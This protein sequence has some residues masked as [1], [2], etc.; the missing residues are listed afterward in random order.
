MSNT[1][2]P[3]L[4]V[5]IRRSPYDSSLARSAVD[6]ALASAALDQTLDVLFLGEGVLQ[7]LPGQNS[8]EVGLT[9]IG[10]LLS[11]F[12]LYGIEQVYVDA[13]AVTR[14]GIDL[15]QAPIPVCALQALQI[16]TLM[17][18]HTHLLGF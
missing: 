13:H 15:E 8:G 3:S 9:N 10:R 14:H 6:A 18:E 17:E 7:L 11:S 16:H 12:P 5:I 4:L 2:K 1:G